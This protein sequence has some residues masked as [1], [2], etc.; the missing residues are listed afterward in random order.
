MATGKITKVVHLTL[1]SAASA[2]C[3][4]APKGYGYLID[5]NDGDGAEQVYFEPKA[6]QGYS[7]DE[8]QA[9]QPVEFE[10]DA[11]LPVAKSV[12]LA[13]EVL[14]PPSPQFTT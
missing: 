5:D 13:G 9:G 8:L 10:R 4:P 14:S 3:S 6:V 7:F 2:D 11:K 1:Q 12:K